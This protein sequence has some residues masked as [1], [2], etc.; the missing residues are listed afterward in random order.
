MHEDPE[1]VR[2]RLVAEHPAANVQGPCSYER[3]YFYVSLPGGG[4]RQLYMPKGAPESRWEALARD[5]VRSLGLE[6][7]P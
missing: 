6:P 2:A 1:D 5:K 3:I 4:T 7:L